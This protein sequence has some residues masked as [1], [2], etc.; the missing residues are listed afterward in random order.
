[1]DVVLPIVYFNENVIVIPLVNPVVEVIVTL[2]PDA[3]VPVT[4][5]VYADVK[6]MPWIIPAV[7]AV[8]LMD[9]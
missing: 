3:T 8:V 4:V 1:M 7:D 9:V 5:P 2:L 6:I